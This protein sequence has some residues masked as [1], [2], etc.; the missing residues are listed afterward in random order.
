MFLAV[1]VAAATFAVPLLTNAAPI[2]NLYEN[3]RISIGGKNLHGNL[4]GAAVS[5]SSYGDDQYQVWM[6]G[7]MGSTVKLYLRSTVGSK[8]QQVLR[9]ETT[10]VTLKDETYSDTYTSIDFHTISSETARIV[11]DKLP[12][13]NYLASN[14]GF[15]S[16]FV[17]NYNPSSIFQRWIV[18]KA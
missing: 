15:T 17:E 8:S 1:A 5:L 10:R 16:V 4:G 7:K 11:F 14:S 6:P 12:S 2:V 9:R 13:Q 18:R 3:Y